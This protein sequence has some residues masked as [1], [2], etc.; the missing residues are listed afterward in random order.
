MDAKKLMQRILANYPI[1]E[2]STAK[3]HNLMFGEQ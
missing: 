3:H 2:I 1:K